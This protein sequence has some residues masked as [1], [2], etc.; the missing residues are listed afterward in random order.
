MRW[1]RIWGGAKPYRLGIICAVVVTPAGVHLVSRRDRSSPPGGT[2][3]PARDRRRRSGMALRQ[4]VSPRFLKLAGAVWSWFAGSGMTANGV[5]ILRARDSTERQQ[6]HLRLIGLDRS[7]AGWRRFLLDR[8]DAK[9]V[10]AVSG[11]QPLHLRPAAADESDDTVWSGERLSGARPVGRHRIDACAY[12]PRAT[13]DAQPRHSVRSHQWFHML[14]A[15]G[16]AP[17]R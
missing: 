11:R 4:G 12:L 17:I 16:I 6:P 10:A 15:N 3:G 5:P 2:S 9:K 14:F 1:S 13:S 7:A 8:F